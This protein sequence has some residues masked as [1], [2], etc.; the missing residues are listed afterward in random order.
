M[1]DALAAWVNVVRFGV[2]SSF[3]DY[4]RLFTWQSWILGWLSRLVAQVLFFAML[5]RLVGSPADMR[6]IAIGNA[7]FL[8]PLGALGVVSS[9]A[10]ERRSGT[11]HLL[12]TTPTDPLVVIMSRGLYW[13]FDGL[14]TAL[15]A[16]GIV[17]ALLDLNVQD[18]NTALL[19]AGVL[20]MSCSTYTMAVALSG[21]SIRWPQARTF[22]T[23][24]VTIGLLSGTGI[25]WPMPQ[26]GALSAVLH[27]LPVANS[28]PVARAAVDGAPLSQASLLRLGAELLVGIGWLAAAHFAVVTSIRHQVRTGRLTT[29]S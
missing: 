2:I 10:Q 19:V 15:V 29:M 24:T 5:G 1:A 18:G 16:L 9:T 21:I 4:R 22:V 12:M 27:L 14:L 20:A 25:N 11:L 13:L 7:V 26:K 28:L 17:S 3:E 6:Y 23:S 8:A